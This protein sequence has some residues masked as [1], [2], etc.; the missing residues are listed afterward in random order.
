MSLTTAGSKKGE[1]A[2]DSEAEEAEAKAEMGWMDGTGREGKGREGKKRS[3][4][5]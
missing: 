3:S 4:R 2:A 5:T 1:T